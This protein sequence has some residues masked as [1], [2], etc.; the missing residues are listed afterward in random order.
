MALINALVSLVLKILHNFVFVQSL[1][2]Q[3]NTDVS[4]ILKSLLGDIA[5]IFNVLSEIVSVFA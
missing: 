3:I 5:Y 4:K 2:L 1:C